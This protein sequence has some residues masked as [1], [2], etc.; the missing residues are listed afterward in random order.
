MFSP[1][2]FFFFFLY[3]ALYLPFMT[4]T[5]LLSAIY[6]VFVLFVPLV[7]YIIIPHYPYL[8]DMGYRMARDILRTLLRKSCYPVNKVFFF[9]RCDLR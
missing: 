9:W 1:L 4:S 8:H 5:C 6:P 3:L 2:F 7:L